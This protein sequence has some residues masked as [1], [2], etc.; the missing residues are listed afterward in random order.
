M[1]KERLHMLLADESLRLLKGLNVC[2]RLNREAYLLGAICPDVF[3][4]DLPFFKLGIVG[5]GLHRFEGGTA[6]DFFTAWLQE[7]GRDI[8]QDVKSWM[9]GF[10]G[11]LLADGLLHPFINDFCGRYS[12]E[13]N[14]TAS[15]CHHWLESELEA[16]WLTAI[17]P[18]S[19]YLPLLK[20]FA[21]RNGQIIKYLNCFK[22]F[23][24]RAELPEIPSE[25]E[26]HRCLVWQTRL[27]R[28]FADPRWTGIR[29]WL[30]QSRFSK[31][32]EVLLVPQRTVLCLPKDHME[33][34]RQGYSGKA[35]GISSSEAAGT[36]LASEP[37]RMEAPWLTAIRQIC[38][39]NYMARVISQLTN[40]LL[41]LPKHF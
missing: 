8:E 1:P 30:L 28:L 21:G 41:E 4:Y 27:L 31:S 19:G 9:L 6:V 10:V 40:R 2:G 20:R 25:A 11:H 35:R 14:L 29:P 26:I 18:S 15:D 3:F 13:L 39:P 17:G 16:H 36:R 24:M 33:Q 7:E 23:L 38:Q 34:S 37:D 32:L 12:K 5:R 22:R